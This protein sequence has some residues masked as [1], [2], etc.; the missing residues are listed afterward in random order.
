MKKNKFLTAICMLSTFV[1]TNLH[2]KT[3]KG[4]KTVKAKTSHKPLNVKK[5]HSSGNSGI[6]GVSAKNK[7]DLVETKMAELRQR[8][9]KAMTSGTAQERKRAT[10]EKKLLTSYSKWRGTRYALG[11]D[12]R[13]GIDCSA[14]TRRVYREVFNK[15]LPRVSTQQVKQRTRVPAKN[16]RSGDIVYFKPENRTS[17]TA[18]YVGNTL[19]IN[20]SSSKG[21]VMSSLKSPYWRKYFRYGVRVHNV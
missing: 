2:A 6:Y 18:V 13:R 1:G 11:G 5:T 19:F 21:V 9:R 15:E 16:L 14:L 3:A 4:K 17:H 10:V 12:S 8:H 20:A 7:S